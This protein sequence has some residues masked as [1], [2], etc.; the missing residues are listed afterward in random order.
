MQLNIKVSEQLQPSSTTDLNWQKKVAMSQKSTKSGNKN[1]FFK[2][3]EVPL[4]V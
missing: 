4:F 1:N 2:N 3:A